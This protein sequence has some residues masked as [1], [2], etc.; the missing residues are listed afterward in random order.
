MVLQY[1]QVNTTLGK[2]EPYI[3]QSDKRL[4]LPI[5]FLCP[6]KLPIPKV[7]LSPQ[8]YL[9][10]CVSVAVFQVTASFEDEFHWKQR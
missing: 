4:S 8:R 6:S 1:F 7:I 3:I 5:R 9:R 10:R 2:P